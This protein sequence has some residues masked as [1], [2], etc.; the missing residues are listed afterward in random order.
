MGEYAS[1]MAATI[2]TAAFQLMDFS[3]T[4][5]SSPSSEGVENKRSI[6]VTIPGYIQG[7]DN[8]DLGAKMDAFAVACHMTRQPLVITGA[9]GVALFVLSPAICLNGGPVISFKQKGLSGS[10][11]E[12][13]VTVTAE[14]FRDIGPVVKE[15]GRYGASKIEAWD[16]SG[17]VTGPSAREQ[18]AAWIAELRRINAWPKFKVTHIVEVNPTLDSI[19]F[20]A[21][22]TPLVKDLPG[23]ESAQA[24]D[25][26]GGVT[27]IVDEFG[28]VMR[29]YDYDLI[30]RDG[31][32]PY[33]LESWLRGH[34]QDLC[35]GI[36]TKSSAGISGYSE[37]HLRAQYVTVRGEMGEAYSVD[38][39][40]TLLSVAVSLSTPVSERTVR[41]V[42][43]GT[44]AILV[45]NQ[46]PFTAEL[47]YEITRFAAISDG[48]YRVPAVG[49]YVPLRPP[50]GWG[51]AENPRYDVVDNQNG[52]YTTR[53]RMSW[54]GVVA[55]EPIARAWYINAVTEAIR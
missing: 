48:K 12:Y 10:K 36:I 52:S 8:A 4:D 44:S 37:I 5:T 24:A 41:Y 15:T 35:D 42:D 55:M 39:R 3:V 13:D 9:N 29:V 18:F 2:G 17:S 49:D 53:C 19:T 54:V 25:A 22:V 27:Q 30:V 6:V 26:N 28:K 1:M 46:M 51:F 45:Y 31:D 38:D 47:S 23:D 11:A 40:G 50:T 34:V 14:I 21:S 43:H 7:S 32:D 20:S 16:Y 33:A